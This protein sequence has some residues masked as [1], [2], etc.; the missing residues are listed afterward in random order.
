M[1]VVYWYVFVVALKV[2]KGSPQSEIRTKQST[3]DKNKLAKL[4]TQ[5]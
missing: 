4:P 3:L 1:Y 5:E 2:K